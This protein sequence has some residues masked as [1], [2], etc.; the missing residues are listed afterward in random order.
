MHEELPT[1]MREPP[2]L[3]MAREHTASS[4]RTELLALRKGGELP[5]RCPEVD[6]EGAGEGARAG[7]PLSLLLDGYR[8][9]HQAQWAAWFELIES[10]NPPPDQRADLLRRGS[11]FFFD[12]AAR[13]SGFVTEEYMAERD[14][15]LRSAEQRRMR[16]V[17]SVLAADPIDPGSLDYPM[18]GTHIGVVASG[19]GAAEALRELTR[20]LERR[21]LVLEVGEGTWA[22][23]G[24]A[25]PLH[26]VVEVWEADGRVSV[27]IGSKAS[28]VEGFRR[29]HRQASQAYRAATR[30]GA[31]LVHYS[32]VA[33]EDLSS[34]DQ[35][36]ARAFVASELHGIHGEDLRSK[37][38][39]ET[40]HAYFAS[41]QNAKTAAARLGIH[42]QTVAQRLATV[43]ERTGQSVVLRRAEFEVALRLRNHL[44]KPSAA[45][46]H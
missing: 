2:L 30:T 43:E 38:L 24:G 8:A 32:D 26:D 21:S 36:D 20:R 29:T 1:W 10:D 5:D 41:G 28:G 22:W 11:A 25:P 40:L 33:L 44:D 17:L 7:S 9:G 15:A 45:D 34:R 4:I 35:E 6:A 14:R 31:G 42:Q 13:L 18:E 16:L 23:I 19:E 46:S 27:G 39:R 3:E 12:Y 37:R